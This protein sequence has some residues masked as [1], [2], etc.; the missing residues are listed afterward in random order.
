MKKRSLLLA[1]AI[2]LVPVTAGFA[3]TTPSNSS[4]SSSDDAQ[5]ATFGQNEIVVTG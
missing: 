4:S 2:G 1:T 5:D 3:Q